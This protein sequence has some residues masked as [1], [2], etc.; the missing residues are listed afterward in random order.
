VDNIL[1]SEVRSRSRAGRRTNPSPGPESDLERVF[2]WDLDE[3]IIIFHSLLTGVYAQRYGK[4]CTV[5]ILSV[6]SWV[7]A[8]GVYHH[9][10]QYFSYIVAV[11]FSSGENHKPAA[12]NRQ[13]LSHKVV[14]STPS[15]E[16]D[17]NSQLKW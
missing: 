10:Q 13:T 8:Y 17:S 12:S 2:V 9:F 6:C 3:T 15:H 14:S 16:Q 5:L 1:F 11:S 4:V 7:W